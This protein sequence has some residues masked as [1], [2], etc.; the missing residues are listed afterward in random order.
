MIVTHFCSLVTLFTLSVSLPLPPGRLG[1]WDPDERDREAHN[2]WFETHKRHIMNKDWRAVNPKDYIAHDKF[3]IADGYDID[4]LIIEEMQ[5]LGD[6]VLAMESEAS[7]RPRN[8]RGHHK[9]KKKEMKKKR[10]IP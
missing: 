10:D 8:A 6:P 9:R 3:N 2:R 7:R 5:L 1:T 4:L